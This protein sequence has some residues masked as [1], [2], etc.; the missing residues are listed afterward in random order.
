MNKTLILIR[1]A[2]RD[3]SN[4]ELDN[5]LSAK[6]K[7]QAKFLKRFFAERFSPDDTRQG[8]WLL[9]S[10][11]K[12]CFE[13]LEPIAKHAESTIDRNPDLDEGQNGESI[14][15]MTKRVQHFLHEWHQHQA[16]ITVAC[17]HG[18]WLPI[19]VSELLG[20]GHEMKKGSW[21]EVELENSQP[22]LKWYIPSFRIFYS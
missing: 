22:Q 9:A 14:E 10:P 21:F 15:A 20:F 7:D 12:R 5:G 8:L 13:T 1:H 4:R 3:T 19:A 17:S 6:G 18:D 2:H 16:G 11:K